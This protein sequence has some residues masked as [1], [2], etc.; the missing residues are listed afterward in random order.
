MNATLLNPSGV[1]HPDGVV[2]LRA[3]YKFGDLA[4]INVSPPDFE[5]AT[6]GKEIFTSAAVMNGAS[7]NYTRDSAMPELLNG[8]QVSWQWF[9]VFWARPMLGRV[10]RAD[11]D[12]PGANHEVVLSYRT[13][14]KRFGSD[15]NVLGRKLELNREYYE[16]VGVMGPDF[17]WPNKAELWTP[18]ALK[19]SVLTDPNSRFNEYLFGVARLRPGK[20]NAEANAY[21][22]HRI[23]LVRAAAAQQGSSFVSDGGWREF[24]MPL[25]DYVSGNMRKPLGLLLG[26]VGLI[27]LI[28]C[29]NIAGLQLARASGRQREISIQIALGSSQARLMR[30]AFAESFLLSVFGVVAGIVIARVTVPLLLSLSA[31][32]VFL[33]VTPRINSSILLFVA[34]V[35]AICALLCGMAPSWHMTHSRWFQSLQES[36]R[37]ETASPARQRLRSSLVVVEIAVAMLLL[38]GAGLLVRSLQQLQKVQTGFDPG[39]IITGAITLPDSAYKTD[40]QQVNFFVALE[41]Q[42]R[43]APGASKVAIVDTLPFTNGGGSASFSIKGQV[44]P[45]GQPGP[46]ANNRVISSD[47]FSTLGIPLL[48]G[49]FFTTGDRWGTQAVVIIDDTLARQYFPNQ[50]PIG[51]Q[52]NFSGKDTKDDPMRTIV[53]IVMHARSNSLEADTNEGF[54]YFPIDQYPNTSVYIAVRTTGSPVAIE[55]ALRDAVRAVD[56]TQALY[57]VKTMDERVDDSLLS[58]RFIVVL[59]SIFAGLALL[60]SALGLYG[61]INYSVKL[62]TRELGVRMAL[63]AQRGDVLRLVLGRGVQLAA[64][65]LVVGLAASFAL[66]R[67]LDSLLYHVSIFNPVALFATSSLLAATVLLASYLPARRAARLDPMRTLRE[68]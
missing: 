35:G 6:E 54:Y 65:G 52:I 19:P 27:L 24:S 64:L 10:F 7:F 34:G 2:A 11:E 8:A 23:E 32:S 38:F 68:E 20:T 59:L 33:N 5:D 53:G 25:I 62:R 63:G 42:L 4:N 37:S 55:N 12:V 14:Q 18:L 15:P 49:R 39:H 43:N 17:A 28:A 26:A 1:P 13:W 58:R 67:V 40:E 41:S 60:L 29:A 46:H 16:V 57:D 22:G 48:R 21:F 36:G 47:Y 56:S 51:Q 66:G 9:D 44:V 61:V 30:Q 45:K 3:G 31:P 50:D